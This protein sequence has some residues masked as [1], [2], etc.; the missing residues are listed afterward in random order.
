MRRQKRAEKTDFREGSFGEDTASKEVSGTT[1]R[2]ELE[3]VVDMRYEGA[4]VEIA[5]MHGW[6]GGLT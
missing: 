4:A 6:E 1:L 2:L 5:A 3:G